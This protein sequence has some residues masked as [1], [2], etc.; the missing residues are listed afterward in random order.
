MENPDQPQKIMDDVVVSM[1]YTLKV[2]GEIVDSCPDN[3]PLLYL[4]GH[5]NIIPGLERDLEGMT[6][7]ESKKVIVHPRDGYGEHDPKAVKAFPRA[8]FPKDFPLE[9]GIEL[10]FDEEDGENQPYFGTIVSA[11]ENYIEVDMNHPLSGKELEFLINIVGLRYAT[12][13]ELC[14]GHVH[15]GDHYEGEDFCEEDCD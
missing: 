5:A 2:N 13:D 4:Q 15:P 7:G 9:V 14:H 3:D 8:E 10:E 12:D 6:V 11:D 1:A